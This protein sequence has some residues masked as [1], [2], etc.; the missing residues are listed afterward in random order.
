MIIHN[1]NQER[2]AQALKYLQNYPRKQYIDNGNY[3]NVCSHTISVLDVGIQ[4]NKIY[5]YQKKKKK[6][7]VLCFLPENDLDVP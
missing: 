1:F 6:S 5:V 3:I 4:N 7:I 2:K